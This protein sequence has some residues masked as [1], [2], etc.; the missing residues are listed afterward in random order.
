[1]F[2]CF[3]NLIY[4]LILIEKSQKKPRRKIIVRNTQKLTCNAWG[5]GGE[6]TR[7]KY[8]IALKNGTIY[9]YKRPQCATWT[10]NR[11]KHF[12]SALYIQC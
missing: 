12:K 6:G 8:H 11:N 1:M 3:N 9:G 2:L 10:Q 5:G 4:L 7:V